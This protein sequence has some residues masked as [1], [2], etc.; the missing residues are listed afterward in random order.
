MPGK[1]QRYSSRIDS[2]LMKEKD[3]VAQEV[4]RASACLSFRTAGNINYHH[5]QLGENTVEE[6]AHQGLM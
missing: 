3:L 4:T 6:V 5:A 1:R 2:S